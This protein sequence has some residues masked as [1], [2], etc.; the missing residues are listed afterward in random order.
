MLFLLPLR[1]LRAY[2]PQLDQ[3]NSNG[4][5]QRW[6]TILA[7]DP[8]ADALLV[9]N[10]RNDIVPLFYL[11]SVE[12]RAQGLTGLFPLI[13]PGDRFADIGATVDTALIDGG[14][15]PVL[16]IKEMPGLE[17]KYALSPQTPPLVEV[18]GPAI[19]SPP[20]TPVNQ[21]LGPLHLAG[22]DWDDGADGAV[23]VDLHW[24]VDGLLDG[25]YTTT[26]QLFDAAGE[27]IGQDDRAAGGLYYPTSFWKPGEMLLDSH[28]IVLAEG[29]MPATMLVGMYTGPEFEPLAPP[30]EIPLPSV[31]NE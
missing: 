5:R 3:S 21:S 10:D 12:H 27:K 30:L 9:S 23:L 26:V 1:Q 24:R 25:N 7:A 6:E 29:A 17:I 16:L 19:T 31:S 11:Q 28:Q 13:M 8:P 18:I 2:S 14:E 15:Q 20:V 4:T 22:Y